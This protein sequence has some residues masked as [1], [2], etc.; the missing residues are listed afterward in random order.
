MISLV[1]FGNDDYLEAIHLFIP[2]HIVGSLKIPE[3]HDKCHRISSSVKGK[4]LSTPSGR[5]T[6]NVG[7]NQMNPG[8]RSLPLPSVNDLLGGLISGYRSEQ[9]LVFRMGNYP[10]SEC[11]QVGQ[12]HK[13]VERKPENYHIIIF[14]ESA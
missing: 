13:D 14:P 10:K 8:I 11:P 6:T 9:L 2:I 4:S 3:R 12:Q 1:V 7:G 5:E